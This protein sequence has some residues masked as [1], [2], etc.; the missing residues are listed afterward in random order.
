MEGMTS[1]LAQALIA[2]VLFSLLGIAVFAIAFLI[3]SKAAPFSIRK[4]LEDDQ[5]TALGIVMGSIIIG[6]AMIISA[7]VHG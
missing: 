2:S 3:M 5:N 7:A 4:E 6:L 1:H